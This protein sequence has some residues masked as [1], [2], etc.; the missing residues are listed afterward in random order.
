MMFI[1]VVGQCT[2]ALVNKLES[3][4]YW[5]QWKEE[6]DVVSLN[7]AIKNLSF[8]KTTVQYK[9]WNLTLQIKKFL[10]TQQ[11]KEESLSSYYKRFQTIKDVVEEGW[12]PFVP[13]KM[14]LEN[15]LTAEEVS[16]MLL[17]CVFIA[18]V[19]KKRYGVVAE[20]LNNQF[21]QGNENYPKT[22]EAAMNVMSH[23]M[24]Y[25]NKNRDRNKK[26]GNYDNSPSITSFSSYQSNKS[27]KHK[28]RKC[29]H[30][31][32]KGHF[33]NECPNRETN[34]PPPRAAW[35]GFQA[36]AKQ[37]FESQ[38]SFA[39]RLKTAGVCWRMCASLHGL[40]FSHISQ[41]ARRQGLLSPGAPP[42]DLHW[43][44]H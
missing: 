37:A 15:K 40:G 31:G 29:K 8:S 30:C 26:Q 34:N 43:T 23:R 5:K 44:P 39:Y 28:N 22:V 2:L 25:E 38:F 19:D 32:G 13:T 1:S 3:H 20:E 35:N 11:R 7:N 24:D 6:D 42:H 14:A 4:P 12:G 41:T 27:N 16:N 17:A 33:N 9:P 36:H 21:L 18:G 10:N